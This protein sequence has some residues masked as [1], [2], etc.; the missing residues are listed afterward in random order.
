MLDNKNL[1][2]LKQISSIIQ[3]TTFHNVLLLLKLF[4]KVINNSN[5]NSSSS[6]KRNISF[7]LLPNI[8]LKELSNL[9]FNSFN[10]NNKLKTNLE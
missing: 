8:I 3:P 7:K 4:N 5:K 6:T 2:Q 1:C 9:I 10:D